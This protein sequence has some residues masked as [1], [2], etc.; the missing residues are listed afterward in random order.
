MSNKNTLNENKKFYSLSQIL[1]H[2]LIALLVFYQLVTS[3]YM[4]ENYQTFLNTGDWPHYFSYKTKIHIAIWIFLL[5]G[6]LIRI[7][8]RFKTKVPK[9][10]P[11]ISTL[12][13]VIAKS[14][15]FFLYFLLFLMPISGIAGWFWKLTFLITV[16]ILSYEILLAL[17]LFHICAVMFHEGILGNKIIHRMLQYKETSKR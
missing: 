2:W 16:H 10:P 11:D 9:L 1:L 13:T 6:M 17:I 14:S 12:L 15:H 7:Y 4:Q 3:D 5:F 8:L